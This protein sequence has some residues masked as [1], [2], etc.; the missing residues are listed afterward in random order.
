[1]TTAIMLIS[2]L[3]PWTEPTPEQVV[4]GQAKY[5]GEG[6]MERAAV[7]Q[8]LD[9]RWYADGV[10]LMSRGDL[11][12]VVWVSHGDE[13]LG[14]FLVVDCAQRNHYDRRVAQGDVLEVS[15]ELAQKWGMKGPEE[16][17][18]WFTEPPPVRWH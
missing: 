15:Y 16:V 10:A 18:V 8:G 2:L 7:N 6:L 3:T 12:R 14:P 17:S 11:G 4:S 13:I 1:M 5:Y 9:L